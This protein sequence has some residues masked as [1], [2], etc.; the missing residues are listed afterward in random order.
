MPR[1]PYFFPFEIVNK[2]EL[3]PG[4]NYYMKLNDSII[5]KFID[6]HHN[7]PV[8]DL[9]GTFVRLHNE[10][11]IIG[12]R[13]YAVFKNVFIMNKSY[14]LGLCRFM[15]VRYPE[16]FLAS[17]GGCDT[18]SDQ[19]QN[20]IVNTEREVYLDVGYWRFGIPTEQKLLAERAIKSLN[21]PQT[22]TGE[23]SQ[24]QGTMKPLG[25]R[26]SRKNIK[27]RKN[28]RSKKSKTKRRR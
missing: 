28:R 13:E 9:K 1:D 7:V 12:P 8:S 16:G 22:M 3:I 14:K 20:R 27:S 25:G 26:K 2:N 23:I 17:A 24:F 5:R 15:L 21:L 11:S 6:R 4:N 18:Y 19:F 10:P